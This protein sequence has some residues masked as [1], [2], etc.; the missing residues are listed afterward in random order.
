[1]SK[2]T[3]TIQVQT[4][5]KVGMVKNHKSGKGFEVQLNWAAQIGLIAEIAT[6]EHYRSKLGHNE[7]LEA[8]KHSLSIK[9]QTACWNKARKILAERPLEVERVSGV[10]TKDASQIINHL[11]P[12]EIETVKEYAI[13]W[14]YNALQKATPVKKAKNIF[15][16][17]TAEEA[18]EFLKLINKKDF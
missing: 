2:E 16:K 17:L 5:H 4:Y 9:L 8:L 18:V 14:S 6:S 10:A 1:M 11:T 12:L 7:V 15:D 3:E 13:G